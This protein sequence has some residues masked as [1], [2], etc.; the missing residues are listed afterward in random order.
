MIE[1]QLNYFDMAVLGILFLSCLFAFFRGFVREMLSLIAWIGAG[2]ITVCYFPTMDE[3]LKPHF[4]KPLAAAITSV[5]I[6]Y[7]GALLGFAIFNRFIIKILK[8]GAGIGIFD[9]ILG[10][11]FGLLRGALIISLGYFMLSIAVSEKKQPEW[12]A[13]AVTKPY[14]EAG[15]TMLNKLAPS[16]L[17]EL[18]SLQNKTVDSIKEDKMKTDAAAPIVDD[19][20]VN[21]IRGNG[22]PQK[23]SGLQGVDD[24]LK[25]MQNNSNNSGNNL[26][27]QQ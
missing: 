3:M 18:S 16:Y 21:I 14:V 9:N 25:T 15:A 5:G 22:D 12:L 17:K 1:A 7:I 8:S 2:A 26:T 11:V 13:K 24:L 19:N 6:L 20:Q 4:T 10:L 23:T 27:V